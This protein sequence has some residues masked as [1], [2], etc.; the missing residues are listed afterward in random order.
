MGQGGGL[1]E[2]AILSGLLDLVSLL[3]YSLFQICLKKH[4]S[5]NT[6]MH[7]QGELPMALKPLQGQV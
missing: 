6:F 5:P 1:G 2:Q 4:R 7:E 3:L